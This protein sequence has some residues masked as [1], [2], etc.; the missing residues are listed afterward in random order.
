MINDTFWRQFIGVLFLF[1]LIVVLSQWQTF[2][3]MILNAPL[4]H[5]QV[6]VAGTDPVVIMRGVLSLFTHPHNSFYH[7]L[8]LHPC[9]QTLYQ[10]N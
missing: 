2:Y 9:L 10:N 4:G 6:R 3:A 7:I 1:C 5:R 8:F